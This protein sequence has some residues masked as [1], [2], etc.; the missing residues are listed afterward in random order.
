MYSIFHSSFNV[1]FITKPISLSLP[2]A[3]LVS[4]HYRYQPVS[5]T[6]PR[7][8]YPGP[9]THTHGSQRIGFH[10]QRFNPPPSHTQDVHIQGMYHSANTVAFHAEFKGL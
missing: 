6:N 5:D 4:G 10:E 3:D 8:H 9:R 2:L 1:I 7:Q